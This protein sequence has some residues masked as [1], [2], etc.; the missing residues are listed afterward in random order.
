MI[1]WFDFSFQTEL[2]IFTA[3]KECLGSRYSWLIKT[4]KTVMIVLFQKR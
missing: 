1:L 4:L 3:F 2:F